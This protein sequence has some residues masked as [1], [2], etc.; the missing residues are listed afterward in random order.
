MPLDRDIATNL[1]A[2]ISTDTGSFQYPQ[3]TARTY[4]IG[5]ALI[6]LG[7]NGRRHLA[8]RFTRATRCAGWNSCARCSTR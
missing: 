8:R 4:E 7:V 1:F 5:A 6:R 3:T 2:A